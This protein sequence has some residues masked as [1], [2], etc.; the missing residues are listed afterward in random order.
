MCAHGPP[1][2]CGVRNYYPKARHC[3]MIAYELALLKKSG[4]EYF[5]DLR[6]QLAVPGDDI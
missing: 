6:Y 2:A 3:G 1:W 4:S 5:L